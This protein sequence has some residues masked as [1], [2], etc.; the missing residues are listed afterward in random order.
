M[1]LLLFDDEAADG[2][3]PFALTRPVGELLFGTLRL[4]D[5]L[6]R[7]AGTEAAGHLVRRG[8]AS[9]YAE[10][11][12]PPARRPADTGG[13]PDGNHE[14]ADEARLLLL[15]RFVPDRGEGLSIP[16]RDR[17]AVLRCGSRVVGAYLPPGRPRP[18]A[19]WTARPS[20]L[21]DAAA[22][23]V[24]GRVL[25]E[26][27]ELVTR[28]PEQMQRD[29]EGTPL[30]WPEA[31]PA[32]DIEVVG[33]RPVLAAGDVQVEPGVVADTR[34]GPVL[35]A[36]GVEV[37]AGTRL[38][39][40]LYVG[41][42]SRLLGGKISCSAAGP[43]SYLHGEVEESV[44]L[45]Y[46]NKSHHGFLGHSYLGRWV[47]L[48]AGT[49]NSDL[50]NNY[51]PVRI[52]GPDGQRDTDVLKLGVF[53]GDHAK[54]GI[55]TL[56]T[57]GTVVGAGSNVFGGGTVPKWVPPFSWGRGDALDVHRR[58]DFL[59]TAARVLPRRDVE[60]TGDVREWLAA[61]WDEARG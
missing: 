18:G 33:D 21:E 22:V 5:R 60:P 31:G 9:S 59:E 28:N 57:G 55:G 51:S 42:H 37:T 26:V 1:K 53:L 49:T 10:P 61:A 34:P 43:C 50:K 35:L 2:W 3:R 56:L 41:P 30:P 45:G 40:P 23:E 8:G 16:D 25:E 29:L 7:W 6:E 58:R 36:P 17:A 20:P 15:S 12:A 39:G 46:T 54:T 44:V 48:G 24:G 38:E 11:G 52:A 14:G 19:G 13:A 32:D 4:R 27:W 47:N